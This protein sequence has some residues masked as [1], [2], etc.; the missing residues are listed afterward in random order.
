[1][2]MRRLDGADG[3]VVTDLDDLGMHAGVARCAPKVLADSAWLLARC[4]TYQYAAAERAVGGASV[5]INAAPDARATTI[6]AVVAALGDLAAAGLALDAGRGLSDADLAPLHAADGRPDGFAAGRERL[7]AEGVAAAI[8][9]VRPLDGATVA[10]ESLD[11]QSAALAVAVTQRGARVVAIASGADAVT[12]PGGVD[13]D[14]LAG[15]A[16][17]PTAAAGGAAGDGGL[18][19]LGTTAARDDVLTAEVDVLAVGSKLGAIDH[20]VATG[21][22]ASVI[23]P[24][25]WVPVTTRALAVLTR[26]EV[27]VLPDFVALAGAIPA[28]GLGADVADDPLAAASTLVGALIAESAAGVGEAWPNLVLA[29]CARAEAFLTGGGHELPQS[30]PLG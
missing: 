23:A 28:S 27:L 21:V 26:A 5:G 15:V 3:F 4:A 8:E 1:M 13:P 14:A 19:T 20:T 17:S 29:A 7:V 25:N 30:R 12:N 16:D 11:S 9:A 22:Q 18:G 24:S 2:G 10:L 6:P